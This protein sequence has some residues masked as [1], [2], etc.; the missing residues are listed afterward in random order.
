MEGP[1]DT[2]CE[3][4]DKS[5]QGEPVT[6]RDAETRQIPHEVTVVTPTVTE[7]G[8]AVPVLTQAH[9]DALSGSIELVRSE[10]RVR[11]AMLLEQLYRYLRQ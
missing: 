1:G 2:N 10:G 5:F 7:L 11:D 3:G 4:N 9:L 8:L 6:S